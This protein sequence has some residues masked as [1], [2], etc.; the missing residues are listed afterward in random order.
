MAKTHPERYAN[1]PFTVQYRQNGRRIRAKMLYKQR[2]I[3]T[4]KKG[5][6]PLR[7]NF[8]ELHETLY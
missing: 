5:H 6:F 8:S 7:N 2:K 1:T 4:A 3:T